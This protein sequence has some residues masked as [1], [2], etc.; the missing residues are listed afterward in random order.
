[1]GVVRDRYGRSRTV[2]TTLGLVIDRRRVAET[3]QLYTIEYMSSEHRGIIMHSEIREAA[4]T[5][6]ALAYAKGELPG[7][8]ALSDKS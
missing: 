6:D 2:M 5:T 1:M 4:S 8:A 3:L 7:V